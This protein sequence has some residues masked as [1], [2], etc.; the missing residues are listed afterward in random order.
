MTRESVGNAFFCSLRLVEATFLAC[1]SKRAVRAV[2]DARID[3][4]LRKSFGS[5]DDKQILLRVRVKI[6]IIGGMEIVDV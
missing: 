3:M 1:R 6:G 5:V 4:A 2:A